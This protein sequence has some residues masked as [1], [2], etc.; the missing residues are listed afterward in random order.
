MTYRQLG[1]TGLEVSSL[2]FGCGAVG[3]LLV[4]GDPAER[5]RVV[6]RAIE[7]GVNYFDTAAI[8]G[9]G[10]S[11]TN[12]GLVLEELGPPVVVGTKVRLLAEEITG[13][14]ERAV[15][16]SVENSLG[17]PRRADSTTQFGV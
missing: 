12:L 9:D 8:C 16:T 14:L 17:R 2:G 5:T 3:G 1:R 13:N 6:A 10:Q 4:K 11:E 7:L 15:T